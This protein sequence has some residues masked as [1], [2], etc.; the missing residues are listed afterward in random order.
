MALGFTL[1]LMGPRL[2]LADPETLQLA[3]EL[4]ACGDWTGSATEFRRLAL[5]AGDSQSRGAFFWWSAWQTRRAGNGPEADRLAGRAESADPQLTVPVLL[6]RGHTAMD[7]RR[8]AEAAFYFGTV[9]RSRDAEAAR[10]FAVWRLAEAQ[11][12]V[13]DAQAVREA[14]ATGTA[15]MDR[16]AA[17]WA[18]YEAGRDKSPRL[19]GWLGVLPGAGYMYS[20]EWANGVRSLLLNGLFLFGMAHTAEE[21]QWGAFAAITFFEITWY[22]GSIYGGVDAAH[23]YNRR[24]LEACATVF[25]ESAQFDPDADALPGLLLRFHF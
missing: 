20:G 18:A 23:R 10:R 19:G 14:L 8:W 3:R 1:L 13:G 17:A 7:D 11:L 2:L 5:G 15:G 22:S 6:L 9:T 12:R 25:R 16:G 4:D 21:G 24:R